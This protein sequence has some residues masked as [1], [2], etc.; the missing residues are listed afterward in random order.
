MGAP[1]WASKPLLNQT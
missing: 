1:E